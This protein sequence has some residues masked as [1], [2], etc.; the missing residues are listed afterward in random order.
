MDN[1]K[2]L[3]FALIITAVIFFVELFGGLISNSLALTSDAGHVLTDAMALTMA[4][5][6]A[7]F[8][9]RPS[10][11]ERTY[12]FYRLE[13]LSSLLNGSLLTLISRYIFYQAY[14]RFINPSE[15]QS[16]LMLAIAFIGLLANA[17]AAL[18][19]SRSSRENL[20]VRGAFLH[21]L[22]DLG[23]SFGVILGGLIIYFTGWYVI[24][25]VLGILIGIL[26]LRGAVGLVSESVNILLEAAPA[27]IKVE[28]VAAT[29]KEVKGVNSIHDLHIWSITS[30][31]NSI[32]A[33]II[34]NDAETER[35]S[36][37]IEEINSKLKAEYKISHSTFQTECESCPE[38]LICKMEPLEK[39]EHEH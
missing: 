25:P 30:G 3:I 39:E 28:D 11:K 2:S 10:N 37:I 23:A 14:Q 26:I 24:D 34:I 21:V 1:R 33:H 5:L 35:A 18:I 9:A 13:I 27:E 36:E 17:L 16:V 22:S 31:L 15:V 20:N 29:I 38:G 8:A 32:S 6:A 7:V 12:G 19:L 4:L